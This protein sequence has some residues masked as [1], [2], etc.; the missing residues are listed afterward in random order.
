MKYALVQIS[1]GRGPAEVRAFVA[2]LAQ[3][4]LGLCQSAGWNVAEVI[5]HGPEHAP[6][7]VRLRVSCSA[8]RVLAAEVGTHELIAKA[9]GRRRSARKR[10]FAAVSLH[11]DASD[12]EPAACLEARD[13]VVTAMRA[14]GPGGQHVNKA[15]TAVRVYHPAS[16]VTVRV[17][18]E[19]SR[20]QNTRLAM[21]RLAELLRARRE[22]ERALQGERQRSAHHELIRGNAVRSYGLDAGGQL[23]PLSEELGPPTSV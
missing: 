13:V 22:D 11:E 21:A 19:R 7:S 8:A 6:R 23:V 17:D 9:P 18:S 12:V 3:R 14:R 10:W 1:A 20:A 2:Q 16:G 4:L 15:S 5:H